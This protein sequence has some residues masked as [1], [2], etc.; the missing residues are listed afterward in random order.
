MPSVSDLLFVVL[1][2]LLAF[3]NLSVKLLGDAGIGW[4]I[5]TG[6]LILATH[7]VPR[8]DTFS[9]SMGG[10]SWFAW[11]W[12]YDVAAG[13]LATAAGLN[14]VVA[15]TAVMI[16]GVFAWMFRLL[17]QRGTNV[18]L[19]LV[20]A[21][22]A[23]SASMIHFLA[24]PHVVSW[25]F[26]VAWFWILSDG[27]SEGDAGLRGRRFLWMLPFS[28]LVW[29]NV[30][31]GFLV[32][33]ALL[34]IYWICAAGEWLRLSWNLSEGRV[35]DV[36]RKIRAGRRLRVLSLAGALS[37][38]ATLINPYGFR[39]HV[40]IYR[41]L[42]NHF[43]MNHIEEFQS[44]NFHFVAQ[45]CFAILLLLTVVALALRPR[46][47]SPSQLLVILFAIY[48][49]LYAARNIP[50]SSLLLVLVIGPWLSEGLGA[51]W[52]R[53]GSRSF[54]ERMKA[55]ELSLRGHVWP[56]AAVILTCWIA[57][58]GG[59]LGRFSMMDAHFDGKRFPV[60]AVDYLEKQN[61]Q[62][63]IL[64]P[65]NWGGYL[66]YRLAPRV[67]VVVDDRHDF[68]GEAF[69]KNYLKFIHAEPGWKGFL[70]DH[71]AQEVIVPRNSASANILETAG[72]RP[73]YSDEVSAVFEESSGTESSAH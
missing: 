55:V 68:Y 36:V 15:F 65:D 27:D 47:I 28:M 56:V 21:L 2:V 14:G 40:H 70:R 22:L 8:V 51:R 33:L 7:E 67:K 50:V 45:K 31:G 20:L 24:R 41:Y 1:L 57:A 35:E 59:N 10:H 23:A 26:T 12:L 11:E 16:A 53:R 44:P 13:W 52:T 5:R 63:P 4:H 73:V 17:L 38:L 43:L 69:L 19:A 32:G 66:I 46:E 3:T 18:L 6:Q 61:V 25:L 49:G 62:G 29:V 9:S 48:A 60:A 58:N 34:G 54:L 71:P 64:S 42:T 72:W 37:V 39:L 30:H